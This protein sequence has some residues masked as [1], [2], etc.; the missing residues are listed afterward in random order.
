MQEKLEKDCYRLLFQQS[1]EKMFSNCDSSILH[2][3][4]S[5]KI[6]ET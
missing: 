6:F 3:V 5:S 1:N 4:H 2:Y